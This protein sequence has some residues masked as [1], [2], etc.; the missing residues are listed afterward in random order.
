[1]LRGI[2]ILATLRRGKYGYHI[3][4]WPWDVKLKCMHRRQ[5]YRKATS[6][7]IE[8]LAIPHLSRFWQRYRC[9]VPEVSQLNSVETGGHQEN[10]VKSA[11]GNRKGLATITSVSGKHINSLCAEALQVR[12]RP[13]YDPIIG[14]KTSR[15][16][17]QNVEIIE[18][19]KLKM[20][21]SSL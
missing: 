9:A 4:H 15:P 13:W 3:D 1:M 18:M 20:L 8:L 11:E 17:E 14:T 2:C 21:K 16:N 10:V 7:R 12:A 6:N 5:V 19:L